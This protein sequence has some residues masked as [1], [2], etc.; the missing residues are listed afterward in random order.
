MPRD[1]FKRILLND[2]HPDKVAN[3]DEKVIDDDYHRFMRLNDD[4][5]IRSQIDTK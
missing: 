2:G 5:C 4:I 3:N 1:D